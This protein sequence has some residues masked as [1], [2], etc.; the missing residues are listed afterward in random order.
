[1]ADD[2]FSVSKVC[3]YLEKKLLLDPMLSKLKVRGE[4][5]NFSIS[6]KGQAYFTIKDSASSLNC[7][8]FDKSILID[9]IENGSMVVVDGEI[10]FYKKFGKV[11]LVVN[12][13]TAQ[14][15]GDLFEKFLLIKEKLESEG[16]FDKRHKKP[17]PQY[18]FNIGV[19]TSSAG[20]AMHD[21]I[22]VASRRF[23]NID[24]K[25][26]SATV[27][28]QSAPKDLIAGLDYF[29]TNPVDLVII[30]R[31]GGSFEDLFAFNDEGLARKIFECDIPIV[32]AV[33][34]E[35]DYS[36]CDFVSDMRAP[37][38]SAAAEL[39]IPRLDDVEASIE[40]LRRII[41]EDLSSKIS[42]SQIRLNNSIVTLERNSPR[43]TLL[44][45]EAK[46]SS[47][48]KSIEV[49]TADNYSRS[50]YKLNEQKE[51]LFALS[52][53]K[54]LS[55]G[56]SYI[57]DECGNSVKSA[58]VLSVGDGFTATFFDGSIDGQVVEK[59]VEK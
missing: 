3:E 9:T 8:I 40:Y 27:Q 26:Y 7:V 10:D 5:T 52:P 6:S 46:I 31:G 24:I 47:L 13:I 17:L 34:H 30:G 28:G 20:A 36:I 57:T 2:V 39:C 59:K 16:L 32:S 42:K 48:K 14:G 55:R 50:L 53:K 25:V 51:R 56:F 1:M 45:M 35:V 49:K 33:G 58:K 22:N 18:P 19:I 21:I 43:D 29:E 11:N 37:T 12:S 15:K 54:V 23:E 41:G 38:P 44:K 4:V